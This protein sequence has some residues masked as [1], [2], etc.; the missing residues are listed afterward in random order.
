MAVK[1]IIFSVMFIFLV[2]INVTFAKADNFYDIE[3]HWA[4][5]NI[6]SMMANGKVDGYP[7][8]TFKPNAK[9]NKL[10]FVK[11]VSDTIG[12]N[13]DAV[14]KWPDYYIK[15]CEKYNLGDAY[16]EKIRRYEAVDI[17]S[18]LIDLKNVR[19]S[20]NKYNDLKGKYRNNVLKLSELNVINGYEDNTFR[21]ENEITRAEAVTIALRVNKANRKLICKTK[22]NVEEKNSNYGFEP[23]A[24][25][26]IDRIRYEIKNGKIVFRDDGR[27]S[28]LKDYVIDEKYVTNKKLIK[29][30]ESLVSPNSYTAVYYVPSKYTINQVLIEYGENDN[31]IDRGLSYFSF[32][33]YEDKLY[34]LKRD[35]LVESFSDECYMK[36]KI[37]KLWNELSDLKSKNYIDECIS[38]KLLNALKIEFG[39]DATKIYEYIVNNYSKYMNKEF[40]EDKINETFKVGDY[41]INLHKTDATSLE[42]YFEKLTS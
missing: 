34:D 36:I 20:K 38:E 30:I 7:D 17:I 5:E 10:E 32:V 13:V 15:I 37:T 41:N 8:G 18:K 3:N 19:T 9:V 6:V 33:Y 39:Q 14:K 40:T 25:C 1:K 21:G 24:K 29:I 27:F 16:Y 22:Y 23:K 35:A 12:I 31:L 42:F 11:F 28:S 2:S 26:A 4:K